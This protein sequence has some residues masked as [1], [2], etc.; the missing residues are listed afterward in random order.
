MEYHSGVKFRAEVVELDQVTVPLTV[1][2]LESFE[3]TEPQPQQLQRRQLFPFVDQ[4]RTMIVRDTG[5][6]E[7]SALQVKEAAKRVVRG[8][9]PQ[10]KEG[11]PETLWCLSTARAQLQACSTTPKVPTVNLLPLLKA[12][13]CH[14]VPATA[15]LNVANP[16]TYG[17]VAPIKSVI[18]GT[19]YPCHPRCGTS[20]STSGVAA[21]GGGGGGVVNGVGES[22]GG[23]QSCQFFLHNRAAL[24]TVASAAALVGVGPMSMG[25]LLLHFAY[26]EYQHGF[27][28]RARIVAKFIRFCFPDLGMLQLDA[29]LLQLQCY[30]RN[31]TC[32]YNCTLCV[33]MYV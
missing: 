31:C 14:T 17:N 4:L 12:G 13:V 10:L 28:E 32:I 15:I 11:I 25:K 22:E 21:E 29:V 1:E 16:A 26:A 24:I 20:S 33:C 23:P 27:T 30:M 8:F 3:A 18:F 7:V 19:A 6:A 5:Y 9:Y 2:D